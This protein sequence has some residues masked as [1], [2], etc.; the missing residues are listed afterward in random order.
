MISLAL[1]WTTTSPVFA[2]SDLSKS[3]D[4]Y[5]SINY[6]DYWEMLPTEFLFDD[7][8]EPDKAITPPEFYAMLLSFAETELVD[9]S[10]V[11][12]PYTDTDDNAWYAPYIQTAINLN[13]LKPS[14][15][16]PVLH[17]GK[18]MRK[19]EVIMKTFDVL[20]VGV[21]KLF[22]KSNFA[23]TDLTADGY[24]APYAQK[25]YEL[26]IVELDKI[27]LARAAKQM[28]KAEV[29]NIL[30]L[31]D[32]QAEGGTIVI[33]LG[34]ISDSS[35]ESQIDHPAFDVFLDVWYT[36]QNNYLYQ[37]EI[38]ETTMLYS[39]I[40]GVVDTLSD[41]YT[42]FTTPEEANSL[43]VLDNEYEGLG[44]S[45]DLI[46]DNVTII[47][48]FKNS[49]AEAAGLEPNDI[50]TKVDGA[51]VTGMSLEAV[52][53]LIKGP[54]GTDVKLTIKRD[55][56][57]LNITVTRGYIIYAS[58]ALEFLDGA[59]ENDVA[60]INMLTFSENT[61]GEFLGVAQEIHDN[62]NTTGI[63]LDLRNNPGG[64]LNTAIDILSFFFRENTTAVI[65][66]NKDGDQTI[67]E[68]AYFGA[69][70]EYPEGAGL[71]ADYEVVVLINEGSASASEIV[72]GALQDHNKATLLGAQSFGKGTVQELSLYNDDSLFK[73]TIS[74]W[75]TPDG[76]DINK[77]GV[78]PDRE[79]TNSA[80]VDWQLD[81]A[82]EE[83]L[84]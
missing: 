14:I 6:L 64:Y 9:P 41:P 63:I 35:G 78:T 23:F 36:I 73:I 69:D 51:S 81:T 40:N 74:K 11:D 61:Y 80:T 27:Y 46:D 65:L 31:I 28:T 52:V 71:L 48:P 66:E 50:I 18:K 29:A 15:Y 45:V 32:Q 77:K 26:G 12:L 56:N 75:L 34:G 76:H 54:S 8:F 13:I 47:S 60:H 58:V 82:I 33:D 4:Y 17:P 37:S 30:Y 70:N 49:P 19:R 57:T 68:T 2:F 79:I 39:A 21:N 5:E 16:N 72:A 7:I 25:A 22:N 3:H 38:D 43:S 24:F 84:D 20:G 42:V 59:T 10:E 53:N 1:A 67:Y 55:S 62:E 44:M 83:F